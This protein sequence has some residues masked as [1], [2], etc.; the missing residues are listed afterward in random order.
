MIDRSQYKA[1][2]RETLSKKMADAK[3]SDVLHLVHAAVPIEHITKSSD[4]N[5]FLQL[6]EGMIEVE[7][8]KFEP[9]NKKLSSPNT[10]NVDEIMLLKAQLTVCLSRIDTLIEVR[11]LPK[12]I[13]ES[14]DKVKTSI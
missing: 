2:C 9:L 5:S 13:L 14:A 6:I 3:V 4:W 10:V 11:D 1:L 8:R 7:Q 12:K